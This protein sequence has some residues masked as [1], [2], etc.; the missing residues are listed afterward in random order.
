MIKY[1]T[2]TC[3]HKHIHT[4]IKT[5][6]YIQENSCQPPVIPSARF[7]YS[8]RGGQRQHAISGNTLDHSA[9]G[10]GWWEKVKGTNEN[11]TTIVSIVTH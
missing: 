7:N 8:G 1:N 11:T 4:Y 2:H 6:T 5:Q 3:I 10:A 9:T